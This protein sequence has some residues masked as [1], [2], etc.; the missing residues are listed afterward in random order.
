MG[1]NRPL[2]SDTLIFSPKDNK[3]QSWGGLLRVASAYLA[4][5]LTAGGARYYSGGEMAYL[6]VSG[7]KD[8][9]YFIAL[10]LGPGV[11][12]GSLYPI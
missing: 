7:N 4:S 8:S 9:S 6:I 5:R 3:M 10:A 12:C 1:E 2:E 11:N